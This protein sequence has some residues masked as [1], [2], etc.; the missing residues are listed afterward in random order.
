[1]SKNWRLF[2]KSISGIQILLG[3]LLIGII[4]WA[5]NIKLDVAFNRLNMTWEDI[6]FI[7]LLVNYNLGLIVSGIGIISGLLLLRNS[8]KGWIGSIAFWLVLAIGTFI[9]LWRLRNNI[10]FLENRLYL[11]SGIFAII[12]FTIIGILLTTNEFR[13]KYQL[14]LNNALVI[15]FIIICFTIDK[16]IIK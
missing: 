5:I 15:T 6:S 16:L 10:E 11:I 8:K 14:N 1:M 13:R 3:V 4:I 2:E 9:T 7:K 12:I